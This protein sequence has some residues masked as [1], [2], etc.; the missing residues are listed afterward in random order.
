MDGV[1]Q[2]A[3]HGRAHGYKVIATLV[4]QWGDCGDTTGNGYGFKDTSW[5][6]GG[7]KQPDPAGTV[8]YYDWAQEV[9]SRYKDD[10]TVMAWQLVNE[11]EVTAS[12]GGSCDDVPEST[13]EADLKAFAS[14]VSD[15]IRAADPNHLISLGTL[16]NGQCGT[17]GDDYAD[18]M[19]LPNLDLCE[20]H[21][22]DTSSPVPGD[23]YNGLQRRLDQC[24][25]LGKPLIVGEL[26]VR[27]QDVGGSYQDRANVVDAK[28]CGQFGAGVA[29]ALLWAWDKDGSKLDDYDIGPNDPVLDVL[30]PWTDPAHTCPL[31]VS[32]T[33]TLPPV[34]PQA[35]P[36]GVAYDPNTRVV[37]ATDFASDT[38]WAVDTTGTLPTRAISVQ[39]PFA[40][41]VNPTT[42]RVYVPERYSDAIAVL[43]G[44]TGDLVATIPITSHSTNTCGCN[45]PVAAAVDSTRNRIYVAN[46]TGTSVSVVDGST[47][48]IVDTIALPF[49]AQAD[50]LAVDP[51]TDRL[52]VAESQLGQIAVVDASTDAILTQISLGSSASITGLVD[53]PAAGRLYAAASGLRTV[54]VIDTTSNSV[55]ASI[56]GGAAPLYLA[57]D[58][59]LHHLYVPQ[60][61]GNF[62]S[63]IDTRTLGAVAN[64]PVSGAPYGID[65][66][67]ATGRVFVAQT[68]GGSL[69][70]IQ[71]GAGEPPAA[72]TQVLAAA[73]DGSAAVTWQA[74]TAP[75]GNPTASFT[76]T[77]SGGQTVT[78]DGSTTTATVTGLTN[79]VSYTFTVTAAN[80]AGAVLPRR[81]RR[82]S[83][84]GPAP[85][86][87]RRSRRIW[88]LQARSR[89]TLRTQAR[90]RP[91]R[92]RPPSRR[93]PAA[94]SRSPRAPPP[95]PRRRVSRS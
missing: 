53:D 38:V 39:T 19:N 15:A 72:P 60:A 88:P 69:A 79:G 1:R 65:D 70:V 78:V 82:P 51:V 34:G 57:L 74:P 66:D 7:Y 58:P 24:D 25:A 10:P 45:E 26:G 73:G 36:G 77:S 22:Y 71:D 27:P 2:D 89:P 17:Q 4:D 86:R 35:S 37:F 59:A 21:D 83:S 46:V 14:D 81:R 12:A 30:Q 6:E 3:R 61:T 28:L 41:A 95:T 52:Y 62:V 5:Y 85:R 33:Y 76:V 16:G 42:D 93:R 64:V 47:N 87:R 56:P 55:V 75:A 32:N 84:P 11:P 50:G 23:Q 9:A 94:G 13:A 68:Y 44:S 90:A 91:T 8:S 92:S 48:H 18:V 54:A 63:V 40:I 43:D 31:S 29:G 80:A 67:P 20:Y 49:N